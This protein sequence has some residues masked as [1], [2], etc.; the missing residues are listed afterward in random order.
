MQ[1][2][3]SMGNEAVKRFTWVFKDFSSL[4]SEFIESDH[5]VISGCKW[6]LVAYYRDRRTKHLSLFLISSIFRNFT[7]TQLWLDQKVPFKCYPELIPLTKLHA[8]DGGFLVNNEVKIVAEVEVLEVINKLDVSVKSQEVTQP[9]KKTKLND[10]GDVSSHLHTETS[11]VRGTIDVNGFQAESVKR[12]FERHPEIASECRI[13]NQDL[14]TSYMNVLLS[15]IKMLFK[16]PQ[17]AS[18]DDLS[19]VEAALAYMKNVGFK[20]DW[21][22][23]K[24]DQVKEN[25]KKCARV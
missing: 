25:K 5:F 20:L 17:D 6:W 1:G 14:R 16:S 18:M 19:H 24:L 8:K 23:K 11:S 9:R 12:I 7:E 4:Q 10:D 13:K 22:E 21:L 15:I 3:L 2:D